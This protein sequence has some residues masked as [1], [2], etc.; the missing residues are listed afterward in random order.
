MA[1]TNDLIAEKLADRYPGVE[2]NCGSLLQRYRSDNGLEEWEDYVA[3]VFT[4]TGPDYFPDA[5]NA[6]WEAFV[7]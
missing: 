5:E 6:Y 1:H 4:A 3:E 2:K 7:P